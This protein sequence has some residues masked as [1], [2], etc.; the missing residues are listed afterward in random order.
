MNNSAAK[1]GIE[2][3]KNYHRG[4]A[5][6]AAR[7]GNRKWVFAGMLAAAAGVLVWRS[8]SGA[9]ASARRQTPS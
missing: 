6:C 5:A 1:F 3:V 8:L 7:P 2:G 4:V 9:T